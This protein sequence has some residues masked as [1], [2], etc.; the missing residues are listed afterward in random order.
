MSSLRSSLP[1]HGIVST[2]RTNRLN[3]I[4]EHMLD[5]GMGPLESTERSLMDTGPGAFTQG[6]SITFQRFRRSSSFSCSRLAEHA[7]TIKSLRQR[8]H[9]TVS[10]LD[11]ALGGQLLYRGAHP[12]H[13][14]LRDEVPDED[15]RQDP[16]AEDQ[17]PGLVRRQPP[18]RWRRRWSCSGTWTKP[19]C[20]EFAPFMS[21]SSLGLHCVRLGFASLTFFCF[22]LHQVYMVYIKFIPNLQ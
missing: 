22:F 15:G 8:N 4:H 17:Q 18:W 6:L 10:A 2:G 13:L 1:F 11:D 3:A 5:R 21:I 7:R 16:V 14:H 19:V 20:T 12:D 9:A